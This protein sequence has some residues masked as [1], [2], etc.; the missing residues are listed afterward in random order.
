MRLLLDTHVLLWALVSPD[1]IPARVREWLASPEHEVLF[2]AASIWEIAIKVQIGRMELP[3]PLQ[4]VVTAAVKSGFEELPVKAEYAATI[5]QLPM[6][7]RDPFDRILI[8]Q[9]IRACAA[10]D[11]RP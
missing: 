4:E 8:A 6:Y 3:M 11:S 7:H 1:R 10:T 2:S 9:A 5:V